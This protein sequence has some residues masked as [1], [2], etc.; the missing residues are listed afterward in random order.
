LPA[1]ILLSQSCCAG[2]WLGLLTLGLLWLCPPHRRWLGTPAYCPLLCTCLPWPIFRRLLSLVCSRRAPLPLS[3]P[4]S[5]SLGWVWLGASAKV[6]GG[7]GR[8]VA[9]YAM[10]KPNGCMRWGLSGADPG[11][12]MWRLAGEVAGA[13]QPASQPCPKA[14]RQAGRLLPLAHMSRLVMKNVRCSRFS[15]IVSSCSEWAQGESRPKVVE[16]LEKLVPAPCWNQAALR[17]AT[18]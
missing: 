14:G 17:K 15:R 6:G 8:E 3:R 2:L 12:L 9:E 1:L 5:C 10:H 16:L 18:G 13:C 7:A 4:F 11:Q